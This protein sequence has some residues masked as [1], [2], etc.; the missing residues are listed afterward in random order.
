MDYSQFKGYVSTLF[1]LTDRKPFQVISKLGVRYTGIFDS[2]SQEDQTVC[3]SE[4]Y[5]HGT[6]DRPTARKLPGSNTTLGWVR[7]HTESINALDIV[8][9][10]RPKELQEQPVDPALAFVVCRLPS[11]S[12]FFNDEVFFGCKAYGQCPRAQN[13][14]GHLR[15]LPSDL[16]SSSIVMLLG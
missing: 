4:V 16:L 14:C 11:P 8:D 13:P 2:I 5:N 7:F 10:H 1:H 6:E 9:D 3:L 15:C 12:L